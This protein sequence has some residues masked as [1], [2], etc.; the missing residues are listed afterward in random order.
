MT[1]TEAVV[2]AIVQGA[3]E[4]FPVSSLGH[5]VILPRLLGWPIDPQARAFLPFLVM[6][7]VGTALALF[8]YFWRDWLTLAVGVVGFG[9]QWQVVQ[10]RQILLLVLV[11]TVPAIVV[12]GALE[13]AL[14]QL[15][16]NP[17]FAA[18]FLIVN[19]AVLLGGDRLARRTPSA[20]GGRPLATLTMR[21][22]FVIGCWQC[23]ALLPGLSRS[24][25]T[26]VGGVLRG[27]DH[28]AA[29]RFSFLIALPIILAATALEIPKMMTEHSNADLPLAAS[30]AVI[31]G[32]VALASTAVLMRYFQSHD[33]WALRPF[34]IYCFCV[35]TICLAIGLLVGFPA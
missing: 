22:A 29:A 31:A 33:Q 28:E 12:G 32:A 21:D 30:S 1:P 15:F 13:H 14:R 4:L 25:V 2:I 20:P 5:A 16:A 34:A 9:P 8:G 19:G 6:L 23:L 10:S 17:D 24:G 35:G 26:I 27:I 18:L 11:A 3:T 7:H